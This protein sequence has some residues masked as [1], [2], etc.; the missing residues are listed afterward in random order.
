[1]SKLIQF[2]FRCGNINV[3]Y[4]QKVVERFLIPRSS[5]AFIRN[6]INLLLIKLKRKLKQKIRFN[7]TAINLYSYYSIMI[8]KQTGANNM[9]VKYICLIKFVVQ[10]ISNPHK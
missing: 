3:K 1:M 7:S 8:Q 2:R 4:V 10:N 5:N 6:F 9:V